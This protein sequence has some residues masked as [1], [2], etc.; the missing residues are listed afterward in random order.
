MPAPNLVDLMHLYAKHGI[1]DWKNASA[2]L[3]Q[4]A[5]YCL[6]N[7]AIADDDKQASDT[8]NTI[9]N[10]SNAAQLK[11]IPMPKPKGGIER[12]FFLPVREIGGDGKETAA[13]ELF[14]LVSKRNC[15]AFRFEPAHKAPSPHDY[16]HV[17]MSRKM[18][19][20]I[21]V[22]QGVPTWLP[23]SYP[24]FPISTSNSV[25]IFLAMATAVHG[26]SRGL[27][28]LLQEIFQGASRANDAAVYLG[29]LRGLLL[30]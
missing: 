5:Q 29:E 12:C 24:A 14:L 4:R 13:F 16:G 15:L 23:D 8:I 1:A 21:I 6:G 19:R 18:L 11:F 7:A 25:R 30:N 2:D 3:R 26:Y 9:Y 27:D 28:L 22:P 20:K 17:Q 10:N